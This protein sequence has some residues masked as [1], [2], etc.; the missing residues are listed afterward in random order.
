MKNLFGKKKKRYVSAI[1]VLV[2]LFSVCMMGVCVQ[3]L[4]LTRLGP[5]PCSALNYG[6]AAKLHMSFGNYQFLF[7]VILFL[8][9]VFQDRTLFGTG[10]LGNM[11]LVGY[12]ADFTGWVLEQAVPRPQFI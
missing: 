2:M 7:N 5:D 12:A 3:F 9:V 6:V 8:I 1:L 11:I 10:S 4:N